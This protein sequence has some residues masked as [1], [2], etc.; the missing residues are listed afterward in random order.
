M[1]L[2]DFWIELNKHDWYYDFSD[3][4]SVWQRGQ[5]R[6]DELVAMSQE[7]P[8]N[9]ALYDKMA[10]HWFSGEPWGTEKAPKPEQPTE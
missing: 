5:K 8:Q 10:K 7:S 3:D 4:H 6:K 9:K 2:K 1:K